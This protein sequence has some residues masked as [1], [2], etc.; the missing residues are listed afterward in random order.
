MTT[1]GPYE[2]LEVIGEGTSGTVFRA[3]RLGSEEV[4]ALKRLTSEMPAP[5]L[6]LLKQLQKTVSSPHLRRVLETGV[7]E[8]GEP[9]LVF[10]LLEG[11]DLEQARSTEENAQVPLRV[12]LR[13][14]MD[15]LEGLE[16][17]HQAGFLHGD[18]KPSNLML[19]SDGRVVVCDFSTLTPLQGEWEGDLKNGTPEYLPADQSLWRSPQRDLH[20]LGLTLMG[21]LTGE[22][23][24]SAEDAIPSRHDPLLPAAVDQVVARAVGVAPRF[25]SAQEMRRTLE[26]LL[27]GPAPQLSSLSPPTRRVAWEEKRPTSPL[28]PWLVALL[29]LPLGAWARSW[30][31]TNEVLARSTALW[32]GVGVRPDVYRER[33]VWQVLILGRPVAAFVSSDPVTGGETAQQRALWCSA[34]LEEAYF[35]KQP[36][37]LVTKREL[38]ESCEVYLQVSGVP[39]KLLFRVTPDESRLFDSKAPVIA[40]LWS[41]LIADTADLVRPGSRQEQRGASALL[42]SPWKNRYETLVGQGNQPDQPTRVGL[43]WEALESL[44]SDRRQDILESYHELLKD[45]KS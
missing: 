23:V 29:M 9:Y 8:S 38:P 16:A 36:L 20:A 26:S 45:T 10:P 12:A 39:D 6:S 2:L 11:G 5:V 43:W 18:I 30:Q 19:D 28:W 4:V 25:A 37:K 14:S 35:Q 40:K 21:L 17:M 22:L 33:E 24:K 27:G 34:V 7:S 32:S 42:L 13:W 31:P 15:T 44:Q 41:V 1:C 3:R